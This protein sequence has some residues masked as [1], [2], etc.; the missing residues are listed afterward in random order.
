MG[1]FPISLL[2]LTNL[3]DSDDHFE[4]IEISPRSPSLKK[5]PNDD[6]V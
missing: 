6:I 3:V 1:V 2:L 5:V 4:G